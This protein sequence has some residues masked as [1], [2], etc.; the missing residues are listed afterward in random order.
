MNDEI[1]HHNMAKQYFLK[2]FPQ[3]QPWQL[4]IYK[5]R[6]VIKNKSRKLY[7]R[8]I[9]FLEK[10]FYPLYFTLAY[11]AGKLL[12]ILNLNQFDRK[13]KNLMEIKSSSML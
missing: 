8:N 6:E 1:R 12:K 9:L 7:H 3:L 4:L 13:G 11:I 5:W 2:Y 10:I